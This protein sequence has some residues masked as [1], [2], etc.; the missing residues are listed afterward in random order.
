MTPL[1]VM[2][3]AAVG[4]PLRY[5]VDRFVQQRHDSVFPWGTCTVNISGSAVLGL[6]AGIGSGLPSG[7]AALLGPGLCGAFTTYSTFGYET[8]RLAQLRGRFLALA[9]IAVSLFAGVG[10]AV[11]G[12]AITASPHP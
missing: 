4:A 11:L 9:N 7:V 8:V 3:G 2:L 1:L 6:L 12:Y 5:L 10:A